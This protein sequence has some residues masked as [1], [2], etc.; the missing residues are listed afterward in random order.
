MR[1]N[2]LPKILPLEMTGSTA[3]AHQPLDHKIFVAM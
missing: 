3:K 1:L 2:K